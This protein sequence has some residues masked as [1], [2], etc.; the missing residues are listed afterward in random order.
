MPIVIKD[1]TWNQTERNLSLTVPL[2]N[3]QSSKTDIL[4]SHRYIKAS[5]RDIFFDVVL[6]HSIDTT[7]SK[8][9]KSANY[10]LFELVKCDPEIWEYL[11]PNIS[12][13]EKFALKQ[14]LIDE[15]HVRFQKECEE[16]R[17]KKSELKK[18]AVQEQIQL[19]TK[20]RENIEKIKKQERML[21]LGDI[22][23]WRNSVTIT[24]LNDNVNTNSLTASEA[25]ENISNIQ[26]TSVRKPV[27]YPKKLST[28]KIP[29]VRSSQSLQILFTPRE[30]PT[31]SRESNLAEET[32]YLRKQAE[33]RRCAGFVSEDI[34][35]EERNPQF[36]L[37]KGK[38]F[39]KNDNFLG[40]ISAFSYG[41]KLSDKFVDLYIA[42][43]EA[44]MKVGNFNRAVNDCSSA[45]NLL[46]PAVPV[47]LKERALCIG[48]RG[49]ALCRLNV[50]K[51]GINELE[52]SLRLLPDEYFE[53]ELK[54]AKIKLTEF[55]KENTTEQ[56]L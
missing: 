49:V 51:H 21:A 14:Q 43:S 6:L 48:R 52:A 4:M 24:E 10:I 15:E 54:D 20:Q 23:Q 9:T 13:K 7:K 47:N 22:N 3:A 42:R 45:L 40:A 11:E 36:M 53:Q 12:R 41:I 31:P 56:Q 37:A 35:P 19:E 33:A 27:Q 55:N 28:T 38:E 16:M 30:F 18:V 5:L 29:P 39:M 34:R 32:E 1:Y 26:K 44:H 25:T 50:L 8:C 46:K 17:L 2:T